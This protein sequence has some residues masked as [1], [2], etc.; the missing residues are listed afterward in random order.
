MGKSLV[1]VES[2]AKAKTINKFLGRGFT[3][4]ASIGHVR[5]LP[6][7]GWRSTSRTDFEPTYATIRGKGKVLKELREAAE[8][9]RHGLPRVR[10]RPRRRGHRVAHRRTPQA[11]RGPGTG[12]S[13]S[14]RSRSSAIL[15]AMEHPGEI[16]MNK[17]DAQQAR[18]VLDRLVGYKVSPVLWKTIYYGLSAG[19]V[20]SVALRLICEREDEIRRV[21]RRRS[22]GPSTPSSRRTSGD[23]IGGTARDASTARRCK[24]RGRRDGARGIVELLK[25]KDFRVSSLNKRDAQGQPAPA[26]HHEHA[27]ARRGQQA[28]VHVQEDDDAR[29]AALRGSRDR[30]RERRAHHVHANRLDAHGRTRPSTR[31]GT[32]SPAFGKEYLADKPRRLQGEGRARRTR[33]RRSGRRRSRARRSPSKSAPDDRPV[34]A[35]R[36]HLA[37]LRRDSDGSRRST[38]TRRS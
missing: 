16:D 32:T 35:L 12:A 28:A 22:T 26:V 38:R 5:D 31:R 17:V 36:A 10:L 24:H 34:P 19:R 33:T 9:G 11:A 30:R 27:P 13:S 1:I 25:G 29:A 8:E 3:V 20:Q 18:R 6:K 4:K 23:E 37:A 2:K 14:T 15:D 7:K 21:R